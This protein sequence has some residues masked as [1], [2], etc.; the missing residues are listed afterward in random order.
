MEFRRFLNPDALSFYLQREQ[1]YTDFG[2]FL[3]TRQKL[4][5]VNLQE[6]QLERIF[7]CILREKIVLTEISIG[8]TGLGIQSIASW[9]E[10]LANHQL[11]HK[12]EK[13]MFSQ[14][15]LTEAEVCTLFDALIGHPS[16]E[17]IRFGNFRL[18]YQVFRHAAKVL[19]STPSLIDFDAN[20]CR[21]SDFPPEFKAALKSTR[22][23]QRL[24]FYSCTFNPAACTALYDIFRDNKYIQF[25]DIGRMFTPP[26]S[27]TLLLKG[28]SLNSTLSYLLADPPTSANYDDFTSMLRSSK[29][30]LL[31]P[32]HE[33]MTNLFTE[34]E[35]FYE[36]LELNE[37]FCK[38]RDKNASDLLKVS[39][40][41]LLFNFPVEINHL[42]LEMVMSSYFP[43][44]RLRI[45][46]LLCDPMYIG[47][48]DGSDARKLIQSCYKII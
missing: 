43:L 7:E 17:M 12:L 11:S 16:I 24:T 18:N 13:M 32:D 29:N 15:D 23:L 14:S 38:E 30:L 47:K 41:L 28:I 42:C 2:Q 33:V 25:L 9:A 6:G 4:Q 1:E 35:D 34:N 36:I 8:S 3:Q 22:K 10:Y 44:D 45:T 40:K 37:M 21:V 39:R 48:V 27:Y 26:D 31:H 20:F 19:E 5:V 46:T